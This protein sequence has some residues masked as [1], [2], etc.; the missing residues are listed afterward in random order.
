MAG[1]HESIF[2]SPEA[3]PFRRVHIC[4]E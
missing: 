1:M 2:V 4:L 3:E